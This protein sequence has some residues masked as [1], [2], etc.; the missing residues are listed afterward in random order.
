MNGRVFI[1]QCPTMRDPET[2]KIVNKFASLGDAETYGRVTPLL[3]PTAKPFD[4]APII[5]QLQAALADYSDN[6]WLLL[7]GNPIL[8]GWVTAIAADKNEGRI[9]CLQ[10]SG[11]DQRYIPVVADVYPWADE[12][13]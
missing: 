7:A 12:A 3:S 11:R 6:D 2:G 9:R 8:I 1:V 13:A 10:W 5:R 4:P